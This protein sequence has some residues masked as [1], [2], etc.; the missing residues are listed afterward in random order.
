MIAELYSKLKKLRVNIQL[1][2][3]RLDL[4]THFRKRCN[5]QTTGRNL[6]TDFNRYGLQYLGVEKVK[7]SLNLLKKRLTT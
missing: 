3:H 6:A 7:F 1:V 5:I 4:Q 2:D